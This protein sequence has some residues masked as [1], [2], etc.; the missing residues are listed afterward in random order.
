MKRNE[1]EE[2]LGFWRRYRFYIL[3]LIG[4]VLL[5]S[6][7]STQN[8]ILSYQV[9]DGTQYA[10]KLDYSGF[11]MCLRCYPASKNAS[12]VVEK[13]IFFGTGRKAS[14]LNAVRALEE[15]A[16]APAVTVQLQAN[17]LLVNSDKTTDALVEYLISEGYVASSIRE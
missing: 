1:R 3:G 13:A 6:S 7:L 9:E 17:G 4:A 10:V 15:V 16:G 5:V 2:Q 11:G 12:D 14:V 8:V